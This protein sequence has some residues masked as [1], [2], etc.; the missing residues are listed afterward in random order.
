[1]TP[2]QAP[3]GLNVQRMPM[4]GAGYSGNAS[5]S[6]DGVGSGSMSTGQQSQA[7]SQHV[8]PEYANTYT[9]ELKSMFMSPEFKNTANKATKKELIGNTI[10]KHVEKLVGES[11]APK[12]T[13]M[14]IDLPEV[15][16]NFSIVTWS[17]FEA[18]VLSALQMISKGEPTEE[19][20]AQ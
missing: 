13:G 4:P 20:K 3:S 9:M 11:K 1:M 19:V 16:L 6:Y 14:L 2:M 10:Y 15:E 17:E 7:V 5:G 12:I 8:S 18:K